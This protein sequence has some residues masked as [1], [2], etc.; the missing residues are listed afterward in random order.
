[1]AI[2]GKVIRNTVGPG[3]DGGKLKLFSALTH[4]RAIVIAQRRI[5]EGTNE[6][7]QVAALLEG[8]DLAGVVVSGDAA[9][10]QHATAVY[11]ACERGGDY[12]LTVKGNQPTLL[13]QVAAALPPAAPGSEHHLTEDR[14]KGQDRAP[15]DLGRA[16]RRHRF[17]WC[18]ASVPDP[19]RRVRPRGELPVQGDRARASPA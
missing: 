2:D 1:M 5:P 14:G 13:A 17:S 3:P 12:A 8:M 10:A 18:G 19:P 4:R 6:I 16:R 7:T 9:H 11:L 15:G